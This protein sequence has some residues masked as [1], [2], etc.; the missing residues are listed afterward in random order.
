[1]F[2]GFVHSFSLAAERMKKEEIEN[3]KKAWRDY[4]I[5]PW[6]YDECYQYF[7]D[8]AKTIA[9]NENFKDETFIIDEFN[10]PVIHLLCLYFSNDPRFEQ[11]EFGGRKYS[12]KKGLWLQSPTR[13]SGKTAL[14]RAFQYNKRCCYGYMHVEDLRSAYSRSGFELVDDRTELI[15]IRQTNSSFL[16]SEAGWMY[17]EMFDENM[18]NYMGNP[19][20]I[21]QYIINRLYDIKKGM[22]WFWKFHITS[23]YSGPEIE[24]KCGKSVRSRMSEMFNLIK[25]EG[26]DRRGM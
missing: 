10:K 11:E 15:E 26:P 2:Q 23:N 20:N 8:K 22:D 12:L 1:M 7:L 9:T 13:G 24:A 21:S 18:A 14:L 5:K 17:D 25:L 4:L 19:L 6:S 3:K 16:Q